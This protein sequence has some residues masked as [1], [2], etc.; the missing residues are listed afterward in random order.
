LAQQRRVGADLKGVS[1]GVPDF[2]RGLDTR[3]S[4]TADGA[5]DSDAFELDEV[6]ARLKRDGVPVS[7]LRVQSDVQTPLP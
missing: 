6:D 5:K 1:A 4:Y 2:A 7:A 3:V